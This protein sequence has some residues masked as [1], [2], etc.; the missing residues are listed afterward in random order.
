MLD[1]AILGKETIK[2]RENA[3]AD[4]RIKAAQILLGAAREAQSAPHPA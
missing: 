2:A 3:R 4:W 1:R